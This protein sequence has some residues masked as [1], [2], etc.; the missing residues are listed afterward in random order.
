MTLDDLLATL[1]DAQVFD[2]G[3]PLAIG[4]PQSPNHPAYWHSLPRRHGDMVRPDGGS[5]ANDI[6]VM[7]AEPLAVQD[8]I[9][10]GHLDGAV[11]NRI[12]ASISAA[13]RAQGC[14]LTGGETSE[15][16][17]VLDPGTYILVANIVGVVE[18][19]VWTPSQLLP[20]VARP[21]GSM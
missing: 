2:L 19:A 1:A 10:C 14:T 7:G 21:S 8:A 11:V 13:C 20:Y 4:M 15:Q 18:R 12:V 6:I 3:R 9:I 5:A 16:P 17:G